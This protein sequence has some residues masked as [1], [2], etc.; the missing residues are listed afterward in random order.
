MQRFTL[1]GAF[2]LFTTLFLTA[3]ITPPPATPAADRL[4]GVEKRKA[5]AGSSLIDAVEFKNIGPTVQSGRVVDLA[6]NPKDPTEFYVAYASGGLWKTENNGMSFR[7]LFDN[8][9]VMTI[10]DIAV[11][12]ERN[13]IW[14]GSGEVNASRSSYAGIGMYKSTDGGTNWEFIGL[15]ESHHIGRIILHPSDPNTAWVAV[16]GHLYSPNRERGVYKTT[17]GGKSWEQT[18]Y[19]DENTG[20]VDLVLDPDDPNTLYAAGWTR[21]RRAWNFVEAG[22]GSGIYKSTNGGKS[23]SL[24]TKKNSDFPTGEGVGRIGL[25]IGKD[26]NGKTVLYAALDNYDRRPEEPADEET[27]TKAELRK[28]NAEDFA[29]VKDYLLE[30]FLRG[31]GFPRK[32]NAQGIK[33][34]IQ[35]KEITIEDLIAYT[36][37]ANSLLFDT[38]VI[39]LEIYRSDDEGRSWKKTHDKY[40]DFVYNSYGY[41]FGQI[42]ISP[43]DVNKIYVLGVPVIRSDDGGKTF[44][45]IGAA[46]VHADHHALWINPEAPD[47]LILGNDGGVNISYDDGTTWNNCNMPPVGQFYYIAVDMAEPYRVYGGLQDNGVWVGPGNYRSSP[48]WMSSGQYPY[49]EIMGGDGMQVAVDTR[50][51]N[52]VYTGSQFGNYFRL[53]LEGGQRKYI[54]PRHELG[55]RP[56]RWNWQSP[57]H[58]SV[59]NQD[60]LYMGSNKMHRSFNQGDD[61]QDI[62]EDLTKGG[63]KGDVAFGTLTTIHESPL[64]FGLIYTGSDDGLVH[65]TRDGGF[66]WEK[67]MQGLPENLWVSRVQASA[68]AEGRVYLTL[69]GYRWDDFTAYVYVSEDYGRNWKPIGKNLPPEPV[70]VIKEDPKN[71]NI[72]YVGTDNGLYISLDRGASF[73]YMDNNLPA[74]AV[75]DVVVHPRENEL[76]VGT[77]GRSLYLADVSQIQQF[78]EEL[79]AE[80]VHIFDFAGQRYSS[81]WG[82]TSLFGGD[83]TP[84]V[85]IPVYAKESG[86][87]KISIKTTGDDPLVLKTFTADLNAGLNFITYDLTVNPD[88]LEVYKEWLNRKVKENE[89]P[90]SVKKAD[91]GDLYLRPGKYTVEMEKGGKI[92]KKEL[93]VK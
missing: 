71:E 30:D 33:K 60:I 22:T 45:S 73:I 64:R 87:A 21:E 86:E 8:E 41:Y 14:L 36:E 18:L 63:L 82:R 9:G 25:D 57:I 66:H 28:I 24:I 42:R 39:G 27:L 43:S 61:F 93:E 76:I 7:P 52:T 84:Q 81:R 88:Q 37:D 40:I 1:T 4:S 19:V 38:Q 80:A 49:R 32:F 35:N 54:T 3:Q 70:N 78:D 31:N 46:N 13:T 51:N 74:V 26:E 67:I 10:G 47:H 15:P 20:V 68:F 77:H 12:W 16:L 29:E 72:L 2:A 85:E 59:H 91:N 6:V 56:L 23:W 44:K 75:H 65:V 83:T 50:D 48:G 55:D 62:S 53:D 17:N 5:L 34:M 90:V 92:V 79:L 69:N 58:L 11:D 89:K